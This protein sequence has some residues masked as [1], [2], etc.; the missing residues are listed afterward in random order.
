MA[1]Q[2]PGGDG[3][4]ERAAAAQRDIQ[5]KLE[6]KERGAGG[7]GDRPVQAGL[8][9]KPA[10]PLPAQHLAKPGNEHELELEPRF[11][12]PG[13][14]GSEKLKDAWRSSPAATPAS[15]AR[16]RCCSRAKAPTWP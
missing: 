9:D 4:G 1:S 7:G 11:L 8:D 14:L 6:A 10:G 13:Y 2:H 15:A 16:S 12:A 5:S 3:T